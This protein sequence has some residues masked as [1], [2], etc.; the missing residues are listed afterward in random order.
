MKQKVNNP[1][2][3]LPN[4]TWTSNQE[5]KLKIENCSP[6]VNFENFCLLIVYHGWRQIYIRNICCM[7]GFFFCQ[8]WSKQRIF[9]A[10]QLAVMYNQIHPLLHHTSSYISAVTEEKMLLC[11]YF[12]VFY[13]T[14]LNRS[15]KYQNTQVSI[16]LGCSMSIAPVN[17]STHT[18]LSI[19]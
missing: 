7:C 17:K 19:K 8:W 18:Y 5:V 13:L 14:K 15:G 3:R 11:A 12:S 1:I 9:F 16:Q 10:Y 6:K 4:W 2:Y